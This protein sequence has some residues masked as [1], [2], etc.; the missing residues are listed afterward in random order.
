MTKLR[1]KTARFH[2]V[3]WVVSNLPENFWVWP[4]DRAVDRPPR[5]CPDGSAPQRGAPPSAVSTIGAARW[6]MCRWGR[7]RPR[8]P[9]SDP[10]GPT[11]VTPLIASCCYCRSAG[12][13]GH[14]T[15]KRV[16]PAR[17]VRK[18][19]LDWIAGGKGHQG[20][21]R[22]KHDTAGS[23]SDRIHFS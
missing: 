7:R 22:E 20:E 2:A 12:S 19:L 6:G 11:S 4:R 17:A 5:R 8:T 15:E 9:P 21:I 1:K 14:N 3:E 13:A 16:I 23:N 10:P 18:G